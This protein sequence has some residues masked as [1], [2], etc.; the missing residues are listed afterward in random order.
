[1]MIYRR[2]REENKQD[3]VRVANGGFGSKRKRQ[4]EMATQRRKK[5]IYR[6]KWFLP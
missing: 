4:E 3:E 6:R 2:E 5:V 1:M